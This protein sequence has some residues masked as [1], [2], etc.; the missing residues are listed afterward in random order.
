MSM[1]VDKSLW[2]QGISTSG[3][4]LRLGGLTVAGAVSLIAL[5]VTLNS[6][7]DPSTASVN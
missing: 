4:V 1:Q 5:L 7:A 2:L 3:T 6:L